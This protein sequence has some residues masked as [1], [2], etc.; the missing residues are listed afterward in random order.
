MSK[1]KKTILVINEGLSDNFGDQIIKDSIIYLIKK[2]DF[3]PKFEDLTRHS[4]VVNH[5]YYEEIIVKKRTFLTPLKSLVWKILWIFRNAKRIT[6]A[7]LYKYDAVVIGG[8]QLLISNGIFP[9]ALFVWVTALSLRNKKNIILFSVGT[10]GRHLGIQK[11]FISR[12]LNKVV[13]AYVRDQK[14]KDILINEFNKEST[15][16]YD[17]AFIFNHIYKSTKK[18]YKYKYLMGVVDYGVYIHYK[19]GSPLSQ[20]EYFDSWISY[21]D[22]QNDLHNSALIYATPED[23]S[24]C[25]KIKEYIRQKF[26]IEIDILENNDYFIFLDNLSKGKTVISGRMHSLIL[27]RVLQKQI[28]GYP[29]SEKVTSFINIIKRKN[30]IDKIQESLIND[31]KN[32][33]SAVSQK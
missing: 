30:D 8:G 7:S 5:N 4:K 11:F 10:Q 15:I 27:S 22:S 1:Q 28:M 2:I 13:H 12:V 24:E 3:K 21:L 16:T 31:F 20:N 9:F 33:I 19:N 6:Q 18:N 17:T 25:V 14:S 23:R 29:I 32:A 26:Y